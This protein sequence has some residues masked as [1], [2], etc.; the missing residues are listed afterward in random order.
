ML[1]KLLLRRMFPQKLSFVLGGGA[2][3]GACSGFG[4]SLSAFFWLL[5]AIS[6]LLLKLISMV[7]IGYF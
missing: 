3:D 4:S 7:N 1:S 5:C 6:L 2:T